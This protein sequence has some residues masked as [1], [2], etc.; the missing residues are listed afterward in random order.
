MNNC[1]L[2]NATT[3]N[4]YWAHRVLLLTA[5]GHAEC[6][7]FAHITQSPIR[8]F[9]PEYQ[10][11]TCACPRV[12]STPYNIQA[13]FYLIEQPETVTVQTASGPEKVT[14]KTFPTELSEG[15]STPSI[16]RSETSEGEVIGISPNNLDVNFAIGDAV[17]KLQEL[18]PGDVHATL[19]ETGVVATGPPAGITF[20]YVRMQQQSGQAL[21]ES[22]QGEDN[23][24][25]GYKE[26]A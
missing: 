22:S 9:P 15:M 16:L 13:W 1:Y 21:S 10:L 26:S 14:V 11:M 5:E 18:Y 3:I 7:E 24:S 17:S 8:I 12:G 6:S 20:L 19:I 23:Q 2:I 4:A 25:G